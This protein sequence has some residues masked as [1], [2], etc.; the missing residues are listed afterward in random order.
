M[1]AYVSHT[2]MAKEVYNKIKNKHVNLDYMLTFSLGGDLCKY[3][4]CRSDSHHK[5]LNEFI[6]NMCDYM[7]ENNLTNDSE[8]LG[9]LYGH[10][11]HFV[12]DSQMHPLVRKV[13]RECVKS[14]NNHTMLE[15][16]YDNYLSLKKYKVKLNKY[17]N[18]KIFKG[19][20]NRKVSRMINYV[21]FE[22]YN[23]KNV[24][25]YYKFNIWLYKKIKYLYSIFSFNFLKKVFGM[26][27][28]LNNNRDVDLLNNKKKYSYKLR[29]GKESNGN[30]D[31]VYKNSVNKAINYINKVNLYMK[32]RTNLI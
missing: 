22:T 29:D 13:D 2:I 8:C 25:F 11:C 26:N 9:V 5:N 15:L 20:M 28:F 3:A 1:P 27:K 17:D 30:I 7:I 32:E 10:I 18:K 16:Y 12:M 14:K 19:K 24:S 21:Y 31:F 4:K 23:C 6:Y